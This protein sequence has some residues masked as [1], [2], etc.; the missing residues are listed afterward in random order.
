MSRICSQDCGEFWL[1]LALFT[2]SKLFY[3]HQ[4][5]PESL[6]SPFINVAIRSNVRFY[7]W[8]SRVSAH[9]RGRY[10]RKALRRRL[11]PFSAIDRK[12]A[13]N[14]WTP[15]FIVFNYRTFLYKGHPIPKLKRFSTR[16]AVAFVQS[17]EARCQFENE[18]VVGAAPTLFTNK[19]FQSDCTHVVCN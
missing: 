3:V 15:L 18:D 8:L 16:L 9:R 13:L 7:L 1:K 6:P 4:C 11:R 2:N 12:C 17:I 10:L 5:V 14:Y 19:H